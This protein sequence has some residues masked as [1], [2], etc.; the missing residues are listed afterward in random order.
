MESTHRLAACAA[1]LAA[2]AMTC[3]AKGGALPCDK[4]HYILSEPC[5]LVPTLRATPLP[6][7]HAYHG[8]GQTLTVLRDGK[9]LVV[10]ATGALS[11]SAEVFDPTARTWTLTGPMNEYRS[12]H[13][14][15]LLGDGR[16]IVVGGEHTFPYQ[17]SAEVFDPQT[18]TW[19]VTGS[20]AIPR[21]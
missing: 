2:L 16:V 19:S 15:A 7:P 17:A 10:G 14:A 11:H 20:L 8:P 4:N 5:Q 12:D 18:N 13:Q 3:A 9:V 1:V 6:D 21:D